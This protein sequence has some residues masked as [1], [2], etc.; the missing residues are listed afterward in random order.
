M[1]KL[2]SILLNNRTLARAQTPTLK[3]NN[4][5]FSNKNRGKFSAPFFLRRQIKNAE[6]DQKSQA[7]KPIIRQFLKQ[8]LKHFLR[9]FEREIW[10]P[11]KATTQT[12]DG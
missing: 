8:Q 11:V 5:G 6:G 12:E 3:K 1:S 2:I 7:L 10:E 4:P 9:T